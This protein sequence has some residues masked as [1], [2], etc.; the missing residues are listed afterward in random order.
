MNT[1]YL[2]ILISITIYNIKSISSV[3]LF[4]IPPPLKRKNYKCK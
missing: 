4:Y 2:I 1:N 3:T